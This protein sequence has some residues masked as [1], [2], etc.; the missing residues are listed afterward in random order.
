MR[1]WK[2]DAVAPSSCAAISN[3]ASK[4]CSAAKSD[5]AF[6]ATGDILSVLEVR[7]AFYDDIAERVVSAQAASH[8]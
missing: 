1:I 5:P 3:A 2:P 7:V 6:H 4:L 8:A